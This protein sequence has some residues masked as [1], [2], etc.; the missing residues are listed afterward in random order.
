MVPITFSLSLHTTGEGE[1]GHTLADVSPNIARPT[2]TEI[3]FDSITD[4]GLTA[5]ARIIV[6]PEDVRLEQVR[7][8]KEPESVLLSVRMRDNPDVRATRLSD[9]AVVKK[10]DKMGQL[11]AVTYDQEVLDVTVEMGM[12][13]R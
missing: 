6:E 9:L 3:L 11:Q 7:G 5:Q 12:E 13:A 2:G 8:V 1:N 10:L 4:S